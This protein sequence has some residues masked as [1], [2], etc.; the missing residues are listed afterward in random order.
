MHIAKLEDIAREL[1]LSVSTVSRAMSGTG[2]VS[3]KT[4]KRV[5]SAAES[6][7]YTVNDVARSLRLRDT[8]LMGIIVPD[9]SN[10]YFSGAIKG[11]QQCCNKYG[12]SL[13]VCNTDADEAMELHALEIMMMKQVSGIILAS[14]R[15]DPQIQ[16]KGIPCVL[17][18]NIPEFT[19]NVDVV[20]IDNYMAAKRLTEAMI[21]RGYC[22]IGMI[23]GPINQSSGK[24]RREGF[25]DALN[26]ARIPLQKSWIVE[27][28]FH[29]ASGYSGMR[30][31]LQNE[32][33][34]RAVI[35]GNNH[36]AY[37]AVRAVRDA[38]LS[39]PKDIALASFDAYDETGLIFPSIASMDQPVEDIGRYA[40]EI[41]IDR[42]N[43]GDGE[44]PKPKNIILNPLLFD[45]DSW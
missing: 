9:I 23:T 14:V 15:H 3:E 12:Y 1:D 10:S 35:C 22:K 45:G 42:I 16:R 11:A 32:S 36:I 37:G 8:H 18:D 43:A 13:M 27:G 30:N 17:I 40:V 19:D 21:Q 4:R 2:R 39:V 31:L 38:G 44:E 24:L 7:G 6:I 25:I 28:D 34:P 29:R 5:L 20:T 26:E 33:F 41:L